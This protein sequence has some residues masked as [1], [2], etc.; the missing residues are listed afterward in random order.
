MPQLR[1]KN[2]PAQGKTYDLTQEETK[3]G[4]ESEIQILDT[5]A[6][7]QHAEVFAIG[8]MYFLRD[9]DSRN[10]TFL[11]EERVT[12][13]DQA[14]LRMGDLVRIGSTQLV[15]EENTPAR[16]TLPEFTSGEEDFGATMELSLDG[17]ELPG[18]TAGSE[19]AS[20]H[21]SVLYDVS[22]AI[23]EAFD[24]TSLMQKV[25]DI[26]FAATRADGVFVFIRDKGKLVPV[27]HKRR[28]EGRELKI[29]STIIK[30]SI[31]HNRAVLVSDALS[32]TRFSA[33][34][35]VV[36]KG[37]RSVICAPL[38]ARER[39]GG[40][41]YLHSSSLEG[42]FTDDQLRLVTAIALEAAVAI[43]AMRAHEKSRLQLTSAFRT[44]ITAYEEGSPTAQRGH[45]ERVYACAQAICKA[46]E[47]PPAETQAIELAALLHEI[48]K[49]GAP[50]GAFA[51]EENRDAYATLGAQMLRKIDG[52]DGVA[53]AVAAHLERLDGGGG[54]RQ[55]VGH[56]IPRSA[57]VV[58]LADEFARRL[59]TAPADGTRLAAVKQALISLNEE[60]PDRYDA[61]AFNGLV[62]ALRTGTLQP[63]EAQA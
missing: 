13:D 16:E 45:S 1:V 19:E 58:G 56:Q 40:V 36:L 7:R 49:L 54:P 27:A 46:L 60:V 52:L 53:A 38:L 4:R 12:K 26:T 34:S 43:E 31:Q 6:S 55:L 21:F 8:D 61:E 2:G 17:E 22:K 37:I 30:R 20:L 11:N 29:S 48:G 42:A 62:V 33:S 9:L 24:T 23:S 18:G 14:L 59:V 15:F 28:K 41:L 25:C 44:L 63:F 57:R 39:I 3:L 50:E 47:L 51:R 32:D 5:A 10:G 35:S